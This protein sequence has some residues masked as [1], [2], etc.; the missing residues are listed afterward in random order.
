MADKKSGKVLFLEARLQ[1]PRCFRVR[2]DNGES[3]TLRAESDASYEEWV[4]AL[5]DLLTRVEETAMDEG[6]WLRAAVEKRGYWTHAWKRRY[7]MLNVKDATLMY[8]ANEGEAPRGRTMVCG[9]DLVLACEGRTEV[10]FHTAN[11]DDFHARFATADEA[12]AWVST[13][14]SLVAATDGCR[15]ATIDVSSADPMLIGA[16][17]SAFGFNR[18]AHSAYVLPGTDHLFVF[19]GRSS[20]GYSTT[21]P[22]AAS[23]AEVLSAPLS[24]QSAAALLCPSDVYHVRFSGDHIANTV[25]VAPHQEGAHAK[26]RPLPREGAASAGVG[27]NWVIYG[28]R[29]PGGAVLDDVWAIDFAPLVKGG[30]GGSLQWRRVT[31]AEGAVVMAGERTLPPLAFHSSVHLGANAT[32]GGSGAAAAPRKG[33]LARSSPTGASDT[34]SEDPWILFS[35]GTSDGRTAVAAC[36]LFDVGSG[37]VKEAPPMDVARA[38]HSTAVLPSKEVIAVGGVR[39]ISGAAHTRA[40][41]SAHAEFS[42]YGADDIVRQPFISIRN[43][44]NGRWTPLDCSFV[45]RR[46]FAIAPMPFPSAVLAKASL[47]DRHEAALLIC[48]G[49]RE[50]GELPQLLSLRVVSPNRDVPNSSMATMAEVSLVPTTGAAPSVPVGV[51]L[52]VFGS[53]AYSVGGEGLRKLLLTSV[54]GIESASSEGLTPSSR[55]LREVGGLQGG[56]RGDSDASSSDAESIDGIL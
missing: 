16:G 54:Y 50:G 9:A 18:I 30:G 13:V 34:A 7:L 37:A 44:V 56:V 47:R 35:G 33:V 51:P 27:F 6:S 4:G 26:V 11:G 43:P 41:P 1:Q 48:G 38:Q 5:T 55:R 42:N 40:P 25:H 24:A 3:W 45:D 39:V 12:A 53:Y 21:A 31:E 32:C 28:G 19:G 46:P 52:V 15:W 8:S 49:A 14:Q 29:G 17:A 36:W 2:I 23:I 10:A 20:N 22:T